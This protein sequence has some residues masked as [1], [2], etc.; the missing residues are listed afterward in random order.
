MNNPAHPFVS[1]IIPVFHDWQNL[2]RCLDA[3]RR[4]TYPPHLFEIIVVNNDPADHIPGEIAAY[5]NIV[6]AEELA[7]SSYAARNKGL[8]I[9]KGEILAFTDAD[10]LPS[11]TW[12]EKGVDNLLRDPSIGLVAGKIDFIFSKSHPP[13]ISECY[14]SIMMMRQ[15]FFLTKLHF[16]STANLFTF[17]HVIEK[18]GAFN[19][20]LK[21]AG[22]REWGERVFLNGYKQIYA[23]SARV[24]H[25]AC[26]F[27]QLHSR[28]RRLAGGKYFLFITSPHAYKKWLE[29]FPRIIALLFEE[30]ATLYRADISKREKKRFQLIALHLLMKGV[31][32]WE[33]LRLLLGAKPRRE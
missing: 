33:G 20:A 28:F 10:C 26:T 1:V 18:V 16:S 7:P 11:A 2:Q 21:S 9:S 27:S 30:I 15:D 6:C 22:D 3:L 25:P 17:K 29:K 12:M 32:L 23:D 5:K 19:A 8:S 13:T 24:L 4:Q 14:S 31:M